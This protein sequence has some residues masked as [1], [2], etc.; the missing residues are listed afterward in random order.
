M[1]LVGKNRKKTKLEFKKLYIGG[2]K[3]MPI[4]LIEFIQ[5][6]NWSICKVEIGK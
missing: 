6:Y 3:E 1:M 5:K 2:I 4:E